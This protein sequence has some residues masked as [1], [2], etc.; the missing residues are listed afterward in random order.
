MTH[1]TFSL[2]FSALILSSGLYSQA[3]VKEKNKGFAQIG[4]TSIAGNSIYNGS[5]TEIELDFDVTDYT[6]SAYAEYGITDDITLTAFVPYRMLNTDALF[7]EDIVDYVISSG[8]LNSLGNVSLG[9]VYCIQQ[10]KEFVISAELNAELPSATYDEKTG[11]RSGYDS[12]GFAPGINLGYSKNKIFSSLQSAYNIRGNEYSGQI[13]NSFEIGKQLG[14]KSFLI[15]GHH[16]LLSA[17]NG[18]HNDEFTVFNGVH[19][20][21][22]EFLAYSLKYGFKFTPELST[23]LYASGGYYGDFVLRSPALSLSV[24]YQW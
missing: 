11:L 7:D 3:W 17:R 5:G 9:I 12:F 8:S 23:W 14:E 15:V 13:I 22:T 4:F 24:S 10:N 20:N 19:A 18:G 16:L 6:L 21:N 1:K 2:I